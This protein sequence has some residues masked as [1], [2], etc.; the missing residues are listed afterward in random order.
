MSLFRSLAY[1]PFLLLWVGQTLSRL[2]DS[3]YQIALAWW[4][5]EQTNSAAA[6]GAV[7]AC[8][9]VPTIMFVL[10]GGVAVDRLPRVHL[11]LGADLVRALL[12]GG[13]AILASAQQLE[14]WHI[15]LASLLFGLINA[16]FLPAYSALIPDM[17]PQQLLTSANALT[18]LSAEITGVLGPLLG[19]LLVG[20]RGAATAFALDGGSFVFAGVCLLPLL[21]LS[22]SHSISQARTSIA[23]DLRIGFQ[24]IAASSWLW[25]T[26]GIF[27]LLNLTG[28]SPMT[29][30]LPFLV[31]NDLR[32]DV[33]IL[34]LLYSSFSLGSIAGATWIGRRA[35]L[36][37]RGRLVYRAL[38]LVG[39]MTLALGLPI[40]SYGSIAAIFIL[41]M[42]L[43]IGNLAWTQVVQAYVPAH[44]FGRVASITLLASTSLLPLGVALAG[45]AT[46][47]V[48]PALVFIIGGA[49]TA[50]LALTGL[51]HSA[52]RSLE[53][54]HPTRTGRRSHVT[55]SLKPATCDMRSVIANCGRR[56]RS[57]TKK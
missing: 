50:G 57:L 16:F 22:A 31:R 42:A 41:G 54:Y 6:M 25:L 23:G 32:A 1:R 48:G 46:D 45:W 13:V 14:L 15:Y 10:L 18:S 8:G 30:A 43:A 53:S 52:I 38:A 55:S 26:I 49:L 51:L 9:F 19:A 20:Q 5:L 35:H 7:Y 4:V 33:D 37:R 36:R 29:V 27:A 11:M 3:L 39:L 34:G 28:R 21:G 56:L 40:G 47:R 12:A 2:G 24:I 17:M 44:V